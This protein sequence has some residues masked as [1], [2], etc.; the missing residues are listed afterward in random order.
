MGV[1]LG[2]LAGIVPKDFLSLP[3]LT[4]P[5]GIPSIQKSGIS[6]FKQNNRL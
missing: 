2:D 6:I 5:N 4:P 1:D 3:E